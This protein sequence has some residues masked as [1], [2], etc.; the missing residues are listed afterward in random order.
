MAEPKEFRVPTSKEM[1]E[2]EDAYALA[3]GRVSVA[4][5]YLHG[6]LGDLFALVIGG[7]VELVLASWSSNENDRAQ[8]EM[9]RVAIKAASPGRWKQT[10]EAPDDLLWILG[11]AD[12]LSDVRNDAI[13]AL[14]LLHIG[15]ETVEMNVA[16]PPRSK[17]ERKLLDNAAKGKKLLD[18]FAKCARDV[19][20]LNTFVGRATRALAKPD[21][22]KWPTPR[23]P[24]TW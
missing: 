3:V 20:A 5:N 23:P 2:V 8:R 15:L 24:Q 12:N 4:W 17:R 10:P 22:R 21:Q 7:D 1:R 11:R 16:S 9:L 13:H 19:N 6:A 14:V 18:Q